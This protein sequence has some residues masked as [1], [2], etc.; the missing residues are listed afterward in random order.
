VSEL[1]LILN[2][3]MCL[4]FGDIDKLVE[5]KKLKLLNV[6]HS[7]KDEA[8]AGCESKNRRE[9]RELLE[10]YKTSQR[11]ESLP[12]LELFLKKNSSLPRLSHTNSELK[13]SLTWYSRCIQ[14]HNNAHSNRTS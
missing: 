7:I 14:V 13:R 3:A 9:Y 1:P 8:L 5:R 12:R 10:K 4:F 6:S 11:D 2:K